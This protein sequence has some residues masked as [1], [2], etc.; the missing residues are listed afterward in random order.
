MNILIIGYGSI[1]KKHIKALRIINQALVKSPKNIVL[2]TFKEDLDQ[3]Y[4]FS[5]IF[6][7][8]IQL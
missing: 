8:D 4:E 2:K 5:N 1:A 6:F 7:D 3:Y